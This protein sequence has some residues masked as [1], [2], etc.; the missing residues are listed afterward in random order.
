MGGELYIQ[1]SQ[2]FAEHLNQTIDKNQNQNVL[3][4]Y[5]TNW[6]RYTIGGMLLHH[7][8]KYLNRHW[9]KRERDEGH[10]QIYDIYTVFICHYYTLIKLK[11]NLI[12]HLNQFITITF[13]IEAF[14]D[15]LER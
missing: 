13:K 14:F 11:Y 4:F 8:F 10:I 7:I 5:A 6:T 2:F 1:V 15:Y 12:I 9:I 3:H